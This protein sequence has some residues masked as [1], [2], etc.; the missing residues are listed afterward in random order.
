MPD[1]FSQDNIR[2]FN[3]IAKTWDE[4]PRRVQLAQ[5]VAAAIRQHVPLRRDMQALELGCGTGLV[6]LE[7]APSL[8]HILAIDSSEEM[9]NVL[10]Q[11]IAALNV[12]NVHPERMDLSRET[13]QQSF[14]LVY[15]AM[16]VHHI[17]DVPVLLHTF[18]TL[19]QPGG[20]L[21][22]ADLDAEDGSF[23]DDP[24]GVAH[25]GFER[26]AFGD[27]LQQNGFGPVQF[28]D[29]HTIGKEMAD[30]ATKNF[31][32]FLAVTQKAQP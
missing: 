21:A 15:S 25:H 19:L 27:L 5:A 7:L 14:D 29:V 23:H 10:R 3:E 13:P 30:G 32:V 6:T 18:H 17:P 9:L 16:T 11:K 12:A 26:K 2:R 20:Y 22:I 28:F 4:K 8:N 1:T 24:T 31:S